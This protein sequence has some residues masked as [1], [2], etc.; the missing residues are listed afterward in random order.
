MRARGLALLLSCLVLPLT[1][2][3]LEPGERIAPFTLLDQRDRP[4]TFDDRLQVLL[5]ARSM[6]GSGLVKEAMR[7]QPADFIDGTRVAYITD[8]SSMPAA[9]TRMF[10]VPAMRKYG[11]PV[12]LD[13]Q[14]RVVPRFPGD[15]N[16]VLWVML[17]HGRFVGQREFSDANALR[18]ALKAKA[19]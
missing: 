8:I 19:R 4:Y 11:Y 16:K 7:D 5:V 12:L 18:D 9:I 13:R 14:S 15:A 2:F 1:A 3:A 17:D 6:T 10:A